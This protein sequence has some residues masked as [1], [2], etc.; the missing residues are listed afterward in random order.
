[1]SDRPN[2]L[3]FV[4]D[5]LRAD[6]VGAFG[7]PHVST[8]NI[9]EL[10]RRGTRFTQTYVQHPVCSPSRASFLTGWYPHVRGH[11]TLTHLLQ[12]A[13][14]NV[15]RS[16]KG[17]GYHVTWVGQRGDTFA[18][19]AT[20][21][22]V[23]EYG[24]SVLP[25]QGPGIATSSESFPSDVWARL[26]YRGEIPD[27]GRIDFDEAAIRTAERWLEAPPPEPWVLYVPI[28][29]PHCPFQVPEPWFSM[30][31]R[32]AMPDPIP[33]RHGARE[34][35]FMRAIRERYGLDRVTSDMW[36]EVIATYYGMISRMDA[37]FGRVVSAIER[38]GAA[39]KTV[40]LFFSDHGEYLGDYG[41]IEKWPSAVDACITRDPLI[42]SAPG[43]TGN[44]ASDGMVELIDV[45]PTMLELAHIEA[46][47]RHYGRSLVPLLRNPRAAH[48]QYAFTEGGFSVEEE[49]Q[50]ERAGF[51]YDLKVALQHEEPSLVGKAVA[52]RDVDWTYAW[53]LYE[54]PELYHRS[55]DPH[56]QINLAGQPEVIE[57]EHRMRD[58]VLRWM[59]DT[60]DV[61]PSHEDPRFPEVQLP[62][63][64]A[65]LQPMQSREERA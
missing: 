61:I 19:G 21:V 20:E 26:F 53:R 46:R 27:D 14:P 62:P 5:Q 28:L 56:E 23:H 17:D 33:P 37:H 6:A 51:P 35:R 38:A 49:P 2:F 64:G 41:L 65:A 54:A 44:Q 30:Y 60:A 9:D 25:S 43:F 11:R 8:P 52:V 13:E 36:R 55:E 12:P 47:H 29:A 48:R 39:S 10:A 22:S 1:V 24:F 58:A 57:V 32:A 15:L 4:P 50:L 59:V 63:P 45:V 34:P 18:P 40:T 3:I 7:N 16:M 42:I 31:D